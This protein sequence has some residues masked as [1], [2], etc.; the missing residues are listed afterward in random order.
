MVAVLGALIADLTDIDAS[1]MNR[2]REGADVDEG[3][4]A[5]YFSMSPPKQPTSNEVLVVIWMTSGFAADYS[6]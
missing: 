6:T 3:I 2:S 1:N 4:H 5:I